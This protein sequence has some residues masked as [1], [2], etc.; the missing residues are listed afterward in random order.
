[1][2]RR[3]PPLPRLRIRPADRRLRRGRGALRR[4][5][6]RRGG[7]RRRGNPLARRG[8]A[9]A[10]RAAIVRPAH[11]LDPRTYDTRSRTGRGGRGAAAKRTDRPRPFGPTLPGLRPGQQLPF[12]A[13]PE[14]LHGRAPLPAAGGRA[15]RSAMLGLY[16][17]QPTEN[18][19][20]RTGLPESGA[21]RSRRGRGR[22]M[23]RC[24]CQPGGRFR[25]VRLL[26]R[27]RRT[28]PQKVASEL[29]RAF[30]QRRD[31]RRLPPRHENPGEAPFENPRRAVGP[32]PVHVRP[33]N[34]RRPGRLRLADARCR[35]HGHGPCQQR[36]PQ[37]TL[38]TLSRRGP[39]RRQELD[40]QLRGTLPQRG[41]P[42]E[43]A[44]AGEDD[45]TQRQAAP[46]PVR[47]AR[48]NGRL[49]AGGRRHPPLRNHADGNPCHDRDPNHDRPTL[50]LVP[51]PPAGAALLAEQLPPGTLARDRGARLRLF[52]ARRS[53]IP[54][55][56][57]DRR[58]YPGSRRGSD[59]RRRGALRGRAGRD[60]TLA[61][62]RGVR[63]P[64]RRQ[65]LLP[66]GPQHRL[67]ARRADRRTGRTVGRKDLSGWRSRR[68]TP[69]T[70]SPALPKGSASGC[71]CATCGR[72]KSGSATTGFSAF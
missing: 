16:G 54:V 5:S 13:Q 29:R 19:C 6:L 53:E 45:Q 64:S 12:H 57:S 14:E 62:R 17:F 31:R 23:F 63:V 1:M 9:A 2:Q 20:R 58:P 48:Q 51:P 25:P 26:R 27:K 28:D 50:L 70:P 22:R 30:P 67:L 18:Q 7:D 61:G 47:A 11:R 42:P 38:R 10:G 71:R 40:P 35:G 39:H 68:S 32:A 69:G 43:P 60:H 66:D 59:A 65:L 4:R 72:T 21:S 37:R 56:K 3:R 15:D 41:L 8:L 46:F 33:R 36:H 34:G 44:V 55:Q 52:R 49:R 24:L